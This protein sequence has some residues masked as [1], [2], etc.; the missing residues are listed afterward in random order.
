MVEIFGL[1]FTGTRLARLLLSRG[2]L[3]WQEA[4]QSRIC[5]AV[6]DVSRFRDL[7]REGLIVSELALYGQPRLSP[8]LPLNQTVVLLVP[9]LPE[10]ANNAL[11]E[12]IQE[13][14]P[15][16]IVYV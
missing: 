10:P 1:G 11:H 12:T 15:K 5:A 9:P 2:V 4:G 8:G 14:A 3:G 6:R 16:R 7:A 13:L